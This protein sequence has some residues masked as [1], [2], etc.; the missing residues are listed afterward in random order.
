MANFHHFVNFQDVPETSDEGNARSSNATDWVF[1]R[2]ER[3]KESREEA[4][5]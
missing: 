2:A 3:R 5:R 1:R 4:Q